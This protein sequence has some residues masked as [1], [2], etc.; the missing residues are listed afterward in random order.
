MNLKTLIMVTLTWTP[1]NKNLVMLLP[2]WLEVT[3]TLTLM[4]FSK[5]SIMSLMLWDSEWLIP[6]CLCIMLSSLLLPF[7][8]LNSLLLPF[9]MVR[10]QLQSSNLFDQKVSKT[11]IKT[12]S[13]SLLNMI[14]GPKTRHKWLLLRFQSQIIAHRFR[15]CSRTCPRHSWGGRR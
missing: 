10:I 9:T 14:N 6:G 3:N 12:D 13:I 5:L 11:L 8:M 15:C 1:P 4:V 7:M 2:V